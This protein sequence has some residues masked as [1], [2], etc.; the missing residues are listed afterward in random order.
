MSISKSIR[1]N[2]SYKI[3]NE[4][5]KIIKIISYIKIKTDIYKK[6]WLQKIRNHPLFWLKLKLSLSYS[7]ISNTLSLL[8]PSKL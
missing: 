5:Y 2:I 7:I 4:T 8:I 6:E 1:F 3:L